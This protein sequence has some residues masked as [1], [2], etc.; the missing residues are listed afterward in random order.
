MPSVLSVL[1]CG[2]SLVKDDFWRGV[3]CMSGAVKTHEW[4]VV[5]TDQA[6]FLDVLERED[7]TGYFVCRKSNPAP[8]LSFQRGIDGATRSGAGHAGFLPGR[9]VARIVRARYPSLLVPKRNVRWPHRPSWQPDIITEGIPETVQRLEIVESQIKVA[10]NSLTAAVDKKEQIIV[11]T[12]PRWTEE[13]KVQMAHEAYTWVGEP[14][15]VLE[16]AAWVLRWMLNPKT[17]K[18]C[19]TL[20]QHIIGTVDPAIDIWARFHRLDPELVAPRDLLAYGVDHD[21]RSWCS[22]CE[23]SSVINTEARG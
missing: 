13:Q 11:F 19:S 9:Q 1:D 7:V 23:L 18:A 20:T 6:A 22:R 8:G 15:D 3:A 16:I 14:Y 2:I 21:L 10:I 4:P 12:D 5:E 17:M